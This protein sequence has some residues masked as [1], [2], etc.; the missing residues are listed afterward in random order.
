M[1]P[2]DYFN[3]HQPSTPNLADKIG[4]LDLKKKK[5]SKK[6]KNKLEKKATK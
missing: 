2:H 3:I 1:K 5:K 6:S 4:Y